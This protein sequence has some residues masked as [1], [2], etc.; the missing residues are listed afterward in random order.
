MPN[1]HWFSISVWLLVNP[2]RLPMNRCVHAGRGRGR[3]QICMTSQACVILTIC[4]VWRHQS[5]WVD[6]YTS[7]TMEACTLLLACDHDHNGSMG[8]P[9]VSLTAMS[10]INQAWG[11][12]LNLLHLCFSPVLRKEGCRVRETVDIF[13]R[14]SPYEQ[15]KYNV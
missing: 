4:H 7:P 2:V 1:L 11:R 14:N 5:R 10:W 9:K 12:L 15:V 6:I 8:Y 3:P 13:G